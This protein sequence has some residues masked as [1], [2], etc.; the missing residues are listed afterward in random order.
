MA[1]DEAIFR[2]F[3]LNT[4]LTFMMVYQTRGVTR[5]A[6][7][8]DVSQPAVSNVLGKLRLQFKDPLFIPEG[9][10]VR[11]TAKAKDIAEAL[12][13]ALSTIQEVIALRTGSK[14]RMKPCN[15]TTG[16]ILPAL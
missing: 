14:R 3:D 16:P 5:A 1:L 10:Q 12:E 9:R 7:A 2:E 13:P 11:P 4:L 8:L 6:L 15:Q